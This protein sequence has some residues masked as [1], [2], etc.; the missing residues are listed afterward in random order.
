[1]S[2]ALVVGGTGPTGP[3]I[4]NALLADGYEV[5]IFHTGAHEAE[6]DGKVEH[7]HGDA[8]DA[9]SI[10]A[11]L[12]DERWDVAVCTSGRLRALAEHLSGKTGRLVGITGQPVYAGSNLPTPTG[13]LPLPVPEDAERQSDKEGYTGRVAVGEDQLFEQHANGD[14]ETVIVRYPGIFGPRAPINH[15]WAVVRRIIDER[16]FMLMPHDGA[17]YFQRG[18]AENVGRLVYLAA[19]H[20]RAAGEAFNAGDD[21]VMSSLHVAEVIADEL[22][23][24]IEFLGVPAELCRGVY[25]LAEK[26]SIVLDMS[27]RRELLGYS[28]VVEVEVA[29]RQTARWLIDHPPDEDD[30]RPGGHGRIDYERED[31]IAAAWRELLAAAQDRLQ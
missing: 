2:R 27:K 23:S 6:L 15:E 25:P 31:G 12:G 13:K 16:P 24:A 3:H 4:V 21:R 1:M 20:P 17:S 19:T 18:A 10:A 26:S 22:G 8:R 28:D 14:F 5:V 7:R 29:T 30:L 9:E 11:A